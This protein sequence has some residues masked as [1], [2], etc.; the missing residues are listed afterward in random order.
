MSNLLFEISLIECNGTFDDNY[1]R[2]LIEG[3]E[4]EHYISTT[5]HSINKYIYNQVNDIA[6]VSIVSVASQN[7][8]NTHSINGKQMEPPEDNMSQQNNIQNQ[9]M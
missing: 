2:C 8:P 1:S 9:Q 4:L 3:V 7:N 6:H 5:M